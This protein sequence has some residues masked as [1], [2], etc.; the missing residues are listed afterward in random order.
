MAVKTQN[1]IAVEMIRCISESL[2]LNGQLANIDR[3]N[4]SAWSEEE[5]VRIGN[6]VSE[7]IKLDGKI[8]GLKW[9]LGLEHIIPGNGNIAPGS[10]VG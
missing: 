2:I 5:Q 8:N 3:G 1:E 6:L 10:T 7:S 4:P 9:V